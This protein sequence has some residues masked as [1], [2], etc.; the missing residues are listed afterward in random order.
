VIEETLS[1]FDEVGVQVRAVE[2]EMFSVARALLAKGDTETVLIIDIG[3]TTTKIA[4]VAN[5]IPRFATTLDVG[6]HALTVAI[7]KHFGGTEQEARRVKEEKGIVLTETDGEYI[8]A[9]L[10][11]VSVI[12]EEI[13]RRLDYW[14][15]K[16]A[17]GSLHEPVARALLVGMNATVRGLPEYLETTLGIPV[18]LADVFRNLTPREHWL[19]PI[20]Y[21]DSLAYATAIGLALRDYDA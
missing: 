19:P 20:D 11:T 8:G 12:R 3:R 5:R 16:A 13:A 4:I 17:H 6:G 9:M 18:E 14:Q 1:V 10:S 7:Q 21:R 2:S 15:S